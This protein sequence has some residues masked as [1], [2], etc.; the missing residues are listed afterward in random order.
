MI[1]PALRYD[2]ATGK[3]IPVLVDD[4]T[5]VTLDP[6]GTTFG[7]LI[8]GGFAWADTAGGPKPTADQREALERL[9]DEL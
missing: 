1:K 4:Q 6:D 3:M 8:R 2:E 7:I 9:R 5:S